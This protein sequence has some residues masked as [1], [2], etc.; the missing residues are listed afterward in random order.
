MEV[1]KI[2]PAFQDAR[3]TIADILKG[4]VIDSVTII[5][6]KRGAVRGNHYHKDTLQCVY[7]LFGKVKLLTQMPKGKIE[8]AVLTEGDLAVTPAW[9]SHAFDFIE[10][11]DMMVFTRGPRSGEDYET[12]TFRLDVPLVKKE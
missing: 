6:S 11:C 1:R 5:R 12:D 9:E 4:E 7:I 10:D 3:G 2:K 8:S